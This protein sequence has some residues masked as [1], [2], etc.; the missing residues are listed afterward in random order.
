MI[1]TVNKEEMVKN[2]N[3]PQQIDV[4]DGMII[5]K[6]SEQWLQDYMRINFNFG[7][8]E[9]LKLSVDEI[10]I[11]FREDL[12]NLLD[13]SEF[14]SVNF[15]FIN[16]EKIVE[17]YDKIYLDDMVSPLEKKLNKLLSN[18]FE[19]FL[20]IKKGWSEEERIFDDYISSI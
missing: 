10:V 20:K 15:P 13:D 18:E 2:S 11:R 8:I 4:I 16:K 6:P 19:E 14:H 12:K 1:N 7:L 17:Q 3:Q 9:Y 5:Y